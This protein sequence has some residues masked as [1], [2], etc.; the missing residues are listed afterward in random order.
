MLVLFISALGF[1]FYYLSPVTI[2][3]LDSPATKLFFKI[4]SEIEETPHT[5]QMIGKIEDSD[6]KVLIV[7]FK[8]PE[9]Q[10]TDIPLAWKHGAVCSGDGERV[11][12]EGARNPG[13]FDFQK[14]MS[15]KHVF[16]QFVLKDETAIVC[17]GM[18]WLSY[19]YSIRKQLMSTVEKNVHPQAFMWMSALIFGEKQLLDEK[20][21]KFFQDFSLSHLLAIS[22][23]HVGL[24]IAGLYALLY[25][26]GL[27]SKELSRVIV[28]LFL[29]LYALL[30]GAA[31]SVLRASSMALL[32]L[33]FSFSRWKIPLS[34]ILSI[35]ALSLLLISPDY[36]DQVGFQFSFLV[37]MSLIL[38]FPL[39]KQI[40]KPVLQSALIC[41]VSQ[42]SIL[43]IHLH[44][45]YEFN[46]FSLIANLILVPYFS[47]L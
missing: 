9:T 8:N 41:L 23:L 20:I 21:V 39:L 11:M 38:S 40:D 28:I 12:I 5:I 24:T 14:Y 22:G 27:V 2:P 34:D 26:T 47:L 19:G 13:Q 1:G 6:E 32:V 4:S 16:S 31:P 10:T 33:L 42:L 17:E 44:Y 15:S 25:R 37:T 46:P 30:A 18:S 3:P 35:V 7:L 45:F 43:P 29:P 36:I